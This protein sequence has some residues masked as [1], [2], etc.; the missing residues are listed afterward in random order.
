MIRHR[1]GRPTKVGDVVII[2]LERVSINTSGGSKGIRGYASLRPLGIAVLSPGG[3]IVL[4][5]TG[6]HTPVESWL[7]TIEGLR[8]A[9]TGS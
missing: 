1:A 7:E 3:I 4:N 6:E 8:E 9:I 5:E 2:P